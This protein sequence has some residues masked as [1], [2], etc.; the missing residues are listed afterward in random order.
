MAAELA[1]FSRWWA[2]RRR[3]TS[4]TP[5]PILGFQLINSPSAIHLQSSPLDQKPR[6]SSDGDSAPNNNSSSGSCPARAGTDGQYK[7]S[8]LRLVVV[9][10]KDVVS[11][12]FS[13]PFATSII[14]TQVSLIALLV[15]KHRGRRLQEVFV[16]HIQKMARP[17]NPF[18][19]VPS[20]CFCLLNAI[21]F[22]YLYIYV[23][24]SL[25]FN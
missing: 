22:L 8:K 19:P 25:L 4:T 15:K 6:V 23:L 5:D 14:H 18:R 11:R 13:S 1:V 2:K 10:T 7:C 3:A 9:I 12:S 24:L 21:V 20:R 16:Y 17:G